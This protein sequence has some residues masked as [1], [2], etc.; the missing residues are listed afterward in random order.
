M[1][2]SAV[3]LCLSAKGQ[4]V[5]LPTISGETV[6]IEETVNTDITTNYLIIKS[7]TLLPKSETA[8]L[9]ITATPS[10][11]WYAKIIDTS[12]NIPLS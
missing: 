3:L 11:V 12:D 6:V 9:V 4:H 2:L 5:P 7:L 1:I 8:P 10:N